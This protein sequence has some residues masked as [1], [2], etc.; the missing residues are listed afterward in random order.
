MEKTGTGKGVLGW[1]AEILNRV[2]RGG[3]AEMVTLEQRPEE[4]EGS[5][6]MTTWQCSR[7]PGQRLPKAAGE[8]GP[9]EE[10]TRREEMPWLAVL[11]A[12]A[13]HRKDL[14]GVGSA[15]SRDTHT[16]QPPGACQAA[17][18]KCFPNGCM[19]SPCLSLEETNS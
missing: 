18:G 14:G 19:A 16:L 1:G 7:E 6:E 17:F 10:G 12:W 5:S 9:G 15:P 2:V 11:K 13:C 8:H 3:L 4:G